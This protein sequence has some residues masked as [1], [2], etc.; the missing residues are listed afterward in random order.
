MCNSIFICPYERNHVFENFA[1]RSGA[2]VAKSI[3]AG[4]RL[5]IMLGE[6]LKNR[7]LTLPPYTRSHVT[8]LLQPEIEWEAPYRLDSMITSRYVLH[9]RSERNVDTGADLKIL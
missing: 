3:K 9:M 1:E 7:H 4:C 6:I 5:C 8:S 2:D